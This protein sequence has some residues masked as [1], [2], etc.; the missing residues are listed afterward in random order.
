MPIIEFS[1]SPKRQKIHNGGHAGCSPEMLQCAEES[2]LRKRSA[3]D[4][5]E[6]FIVAAVVRRRKRAFPQLKQNSARLRFS[7]WRDPFCFANNGRRGITSIS[8]GWKS[9]ER[10]T[11]SAFVSI[12]RM[13]G[14]PILI[15]SNEKSGALKFT[16]EGSQ[17]SPILWGFCRPSHRPRLGFIRRQKSI[18]QRDQVWGKTSLSM[19]EIKNAGW[20]SGV[21]L[22]SGFARPRNCGPALCTESNCASSTPPPLD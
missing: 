19:K 15:S 1:I 11:C 4:T 16:I 9:R 21:H 14:P 13:D 17:L 12:M 10:L 7:R 18:S 20:Q 2:R 6:L 5:I 22:Q 8:K 3:E